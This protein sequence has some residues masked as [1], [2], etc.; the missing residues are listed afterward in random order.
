MLKNIW[1]YTDL[2][3]THTRVIIL[4]LLTILEVKFLNQEVTEATY[5]TPSAHVVMLTAPFAY[6]MIR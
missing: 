5:A 4:W 3:R 1:P 2:T 6:L